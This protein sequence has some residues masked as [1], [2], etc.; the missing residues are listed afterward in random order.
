M[1]AKEPADKYKRQAAYRVR[2]L[3]QHDK[4]EVKVY[5]DAHAFDVGYAAYVPHQDLNI[6]LRQQ[7]DALGFVCG[8]TKAH[9]EWLRKNG[10]KHKAVPI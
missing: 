7:A 6:S 5:V 9:N 10:I 2:Q 8:W 3:T 1:T 4:R